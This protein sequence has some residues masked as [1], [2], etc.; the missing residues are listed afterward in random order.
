MAVAQLRVLGG[1]M[2]R[3]P[4]DATAFAHRDRR[5]MVNVAAIYETR[6]GPARA[7]G[8][9]RGLRGRRCARAT[10]G[11]YVNFLGDEGEARVREAYPGADLGPARRDQ[12]PLRPDEP[13]PLQPEHPARDVSVDRHPARGT[14]LRNRPAF[15][16]GI[17]DA[18][19]SRMWPCD[20]DGSWWRG[21]SACWS[22]WPT[23]RSVSR[24]RRGSRWAAASSARY[25]LMAA[26]VGVRS[27]SPKRATHDPA[28]EQRLVR[29]VAVALA[30]LGIVVAAVAIT[31]RAGRSPGSRRRALPHR[32][33][34]PRPLRG[35][36][37]PVAPGGRDHRG[38]RPRARARAA[39]GGH[40]RFLPG[41]TRGIGVRRRERERSD[42]GPRD[43]ARHRPPLRRARDGRRPARP[44]HRGRGADH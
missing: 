27:E 26:L 25:F 23:S 20:H 16:L 40:P 29:L 22:A 42:L 34:V 7:R 5:I 15:T 33:R 17:D 36:G 41:I 14:T 10:T 43:A 30:A 8:V 4:A 37:V 21:S 18:A 35:A 2:A 39:G 9:G 38:G 28:R 3:V 13:V 31:R 44:H 6:G 11:V 12:G 32:R 19:G 24:A 1:A